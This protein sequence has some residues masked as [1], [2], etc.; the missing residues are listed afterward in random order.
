MKFI[1]NIFNIKLMKNLLYS[2]IL[3]FL[4]T[5]FLSCKK[6]DS[7]PETLLKP[8]ITF[9]VDPS[10]D[11]IGT[12]TIAVG[13]VK[14]FE[15]GSK[16]VYKITIHSDEDLTKFAVTTSSLSKSLKSGIVKTEPQVTIDSLGNITTPVNDLTVYYA[17]YILET[18]VAG[19]PITLTFDAL[20]TKNAESIK[21]HVF[22]PIKLG[23]T[24]GSPFNVWN[25]T[26]G[27]ETCFDVPPGT[28]NN[29][30]TNIFPPLVALDKRATYFFSLDVLPNL[31]DV[32]FIGYHT[33]VGNAGNYI[34]ISPN[35]ILAQNEAK[36]ASFKNDPRLQTTKF[37]KT[38]LT[39]ADFNQ[40]THD[41][42][43]S[44]YITATDPL[45]STQTGALPVV[46]GDV[47]AF[48]RK[49]GTG[50]LFFV[51][52]MQLQANS[53]AIITVKYQNRKPL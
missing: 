49:D 1:Q 53:F 29:S 46:G 44:N 43:L 52:R 18:D 33:G 7:R 38:S 41:N 45:L 37:K 17:Y 36:F 14:S 27:E 5:G 22:S 31:G 28:A 24:T 25:V 19:M 11:V 20:N 42:E 13:P 48:I 3:F 15:Q 26:I 9:S 32:D 16:V 4:I 30:L 23:S 2:A 35:D 21:T 12:D 50:G 6:E 34:L 39:I 8:V 40:I 51:T 47:Y 10:Q